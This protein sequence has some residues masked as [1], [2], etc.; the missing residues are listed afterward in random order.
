MSFLCCGSLL[1]YSLYEVKVGKKG[2]ERRGTRLV[3]GNG[4]TMYGVHGN[5]NR[6][7]A[8]ERWVDA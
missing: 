6:T 1:G 4:E 7:A 3:P 8:R 5:R 2:L